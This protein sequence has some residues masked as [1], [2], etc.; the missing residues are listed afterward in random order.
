[1]FITTF[2]SLGISEFPFVNAAAGNYAVYHNNLM[3]INTQP[4]DFPTTDFY[5]NQRTFPGVPGAVNRTELP[6]TAREII[7][8]MLI[9]IGTGWI[10]PQAALRISVNGGNSLPRARL[11]SGSGP[12]YYQLMVETGD[13]IQIFWAGSSLTNT[14]IGCAF[15][16]YY[17]DDPPVPAFNPTVGTTVSDKILVFRQFSATGFSNG[18]LLGSFT[19]Q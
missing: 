1:M 6:P 11:A 7:V 19:V 15:A 10:F 17:S 8:E 14:G 9:N 16:V 3:I 5:G 12:Q 2:S 13:V 4:L 18:S